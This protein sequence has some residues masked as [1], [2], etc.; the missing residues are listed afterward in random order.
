M[1]ISAEAP[2]TA[3]FPAEQQQPQQ[4]AACGEWPEVSE[5]QTPLRGFAG[6]DAEDVAG[7]S[8]SGADGAWPEAAEVQIVDS[9]GGGQNSWSG[10]GT[11][12]GPAAGSS[13]PATAPSQGVRGVSPSSCGPGA[14]AL[15]GANGDQGCSMTPGGLRGLITDL[16]WQLTEE[17]RRREVEEEELEE[18][19]ADKRRLREELEALQRRRVAMVASAEEANKAAEESMQRHKELLKSQEELQS[20]VERQ[21]Q[22]L[23]QLR[24]EAKVRNGTGRDWARDGPEKDALV[25]TKLQIAEAYEQLAQVRLQMSMNREGLKRQLSELRAENAKLRSGKR[26]GRSAA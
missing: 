1:N 12:A 21:E 4:L 7:C 14:G 5:V 13:R 19:A 10:G 20:E 9:T 11:G 17:V 23:Q 15:E 26:P 16:S 18:R 22:E 25:E 6:L 24:E 8:N 3:A 2:A